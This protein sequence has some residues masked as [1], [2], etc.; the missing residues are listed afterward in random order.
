MTG[1][2]GRD[3]IRVE[4]RA[5]LPSLP[6]VPRQLHSLCNLDPLSGAF[7]SSPGGLSC[8]PPLPTREEGAACTMAP[9]LLPSPKMP[10]LKN[11]TSLANSPLVLP[12][13]YKQTPSI[14]YNP[15]M[16]PLATGRDANKLTSTSFPSSC[17]D[18]G[19]V[20]SNQ[21]GLDL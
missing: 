8:G 11:A 17:V 2:L 9:L 12:P 7:Q 1:R 19:S 10:W 14:L 18:L 13:P 3:D 21:N 6:M 16:L 20:T 4:R 15:C 5:G